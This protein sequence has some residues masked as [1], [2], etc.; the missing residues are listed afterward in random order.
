MGLFSK[1]KK[2]ATYEPPKRT[3]VAFIQLRNSSDEEL[4]KLARE[5]IMGIPLIIN[6]TKLEIDDA[7]KAIAFLS[8]VVFAIDGVIL[9]FDDQKG[10]MFADS[11]VYDDGSV[12]DLIAEIQGESEVA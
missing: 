3:K 11:R 7:N 1:N 9:Q 4:T 10:I 2:V 12:K 8:G 5:I 6:F